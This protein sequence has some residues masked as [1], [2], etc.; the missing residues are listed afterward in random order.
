MCV[1]SRC[2]YYQ[3]IPGIFV[4]HEHRDHRGPP[5][6]VTNGITLTHIR[7]IHWQ[8]HNLSACREMCAVP[9]PRYVVRG[10]RSASIFRVNSK[11]LLY[12]CKNNKIE[13]PRPLIIIQLRANPSQPMSLVNAPVISSWWTCRRGMNYRIQLHIQS[14]LSALNKLLGCSTVCLSPC[15]RS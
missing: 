3:Q 15:S 8:A 5:G 11:C 7:L 9:Q 4:A 13:T 6:G 10:S 1:S 14:A 2:W 12:C